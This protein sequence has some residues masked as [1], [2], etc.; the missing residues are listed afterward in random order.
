MSFINNLKNTKINGCK[1]LLKDIEYRYI[2]DKIYENLENNSFSKSIE[3]ALFEFSKNSE[4]KYFNIT[5]IKTF[6]NNF[7]NE[8]VAR[9]KKNLKRPHG[10]FNLSNQEVLYDTSGVSI[11]IEV[12]PMDASGVQQLHYVCISQGD[13]SIRIPCSSKEQAQMIARN[14]NVNSF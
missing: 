8:E 12:N 4:I 11:S 2:I 9:N 7:V 3:K 10:G 6:A 1:F 14:Y 5:Q 13:K